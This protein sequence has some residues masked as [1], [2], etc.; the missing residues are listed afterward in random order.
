M[1]LTEEY[2]KLNETMQNTN[3]QEKLKKI[4]TNCLEALMG[5]PTSTLDPN[6]LQRQG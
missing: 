1:K 6:E 3:A 2:R 4:G 5:L